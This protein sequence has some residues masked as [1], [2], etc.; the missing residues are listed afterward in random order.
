MNWTKPDP[1]YSGAEAAFQLDHQ[2]A[3]EARRNRD[4]MRHLDAARESKPAR[5]EQRVRIRVLDGRQFLV[6]FPLIPRGQPSR[7]S[8]PGET[9][10][11][12]PLFDARHLA[13]LGQCEI[14][15]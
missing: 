4:A 3:D 1:F 6:A 14:L 11:N 8:V 2:H 5:P 12:V 9:F 10:D 13:A 15:P 7:A